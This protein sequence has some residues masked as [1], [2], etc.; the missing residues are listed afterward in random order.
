MEVTTNVPEP[1]EVKI[2]M[3][4]TVEQFRLLDAVQYYYLGGG[5]DDCLKINNAFRQA[6]D[7]LKLEKLPNKVKDQGFGPYFD[8]AAAR[9]SEEVE[10]V[11]GDS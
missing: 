1:V 8:A 10:R 3:T 4:M 11:F 6:R 2:T 9:T 7:D 5:L